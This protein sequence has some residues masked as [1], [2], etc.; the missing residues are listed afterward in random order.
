M[1]EK[2]VTK[3]KE[4]VKYVNWSEARK[5]AF[6]TSVKNSSINETKGL[7]IDVP[8][9]WNSTYFMLDSALLYHAAFV[10]LS[11]SNSGYRYLPSEIEWDMVEQL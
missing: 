11:Y 9:R 1:I 6:N 2:C 4:S 10:D 8:T 5:K 3:I 7:W